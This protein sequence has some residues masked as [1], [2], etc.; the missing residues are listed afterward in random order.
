MSEENKHAALASTTLVWKLVYCVFDNHR[1]LI[2]CVGA[3]WG[4]AQL[5]AGPGP[6]A[7][8][9]GAAPKVSVSAH[10]GENTRAKLINSDDRCPVNGQAL[11]IS[12]PKAPKSCSRSR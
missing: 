4:V 3:R 8:H 9:G 5:S 10:A 12:G 6:S 11:G 2:A 1:G 7:I